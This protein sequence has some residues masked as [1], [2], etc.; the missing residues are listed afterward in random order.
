MVSIV[1]YRSRL[2]RTLNSAALGDLVRTSRVINE[3]NAVTGI[4]LFDGTYFL[5]VLEG[6]DSAVQAAYDRI[7]HDPRHGQVVKLM[8]DYAPSRRFPLWGMRLIDVREQ[9]D[10]FSMANGG[11]DAEPGTRLP[12]KDRAFRLMQRFASGRWRDHTA[13]FA[14]PGSWTFE[15][16]QTARFAD[17]PAATLANAPCQFALQPIIDARGH[18]V[19][20]LEALIRSNSGGSPEQVFE[21][22]TPQQR[23]EFDLACKTHA[24]ALASRLDLGTCKISVNLLPMSLTAVPDA[25]AR[26]GGLIAANGLSPHQVTVE[27]TEEEAISHFDAFR[28]ALKQLRELG[29]SIAID[30]FGAGFAGLSLLSKFQPDSLKIDRVIVDGIYHDGPR[31]AIVRAIVECCRAMGITTV[32]E[33]VETAEDWCWLEAAGVDLFQGYLFARPTLNG[34]APIAWPQP[35]KNPEAPGAAGF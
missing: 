21:G 8:Q 2:L 31:Q 6:P 33:G 28:V 5:Q 14:D 26:L 13:E 18:T 30:D 20:S 12:T 34:V 19:A 16:A 32:A 27:I 17:A 25:V 15:A 23:Y 10:G 3:V 11:A 22:M 35:R 24:F 7:A 29:V 4:L 1:I 9:P